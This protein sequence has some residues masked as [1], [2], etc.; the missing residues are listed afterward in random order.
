MPRIKWSEEKIKE[1]ISKGWTLSYDKSNDR[2]KLQKRVKGKVKSYSLPKGYNEICRK[3]KDE[4]F[5]GRPL[6]EWFKIL[7]REPILSLTY[8]PYGV[9]WWEVEEIFEKYCEEKAKELSPK[10]VARM[11]LYSYLLL[12]KS[13]GARV[14]EILLF[15]GNYDADIRM[16]EEK[17][18]AISWTL[19]NYFGQ[20]EI[21]IWCPKCK[22]WSYLKYGDHEIKVG[23]KVLRKW[24]DLICSK[25]E[26]IPF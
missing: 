6:S 25:C 21:P 19:R 22:Q 16:L 14:S 8:K 11:A 2:F 12:K 5:H 10:D 13:E 20:K 15:A 17:V 1:Y 4:V 3:I 18:R 7:D 26:E 9:D 23:N 24:R